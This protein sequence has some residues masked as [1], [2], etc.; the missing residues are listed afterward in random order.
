MKKIG[1]NLQQPLTK[2]QRATLQAVSDENGCGGA[3]EA[4]RIV[5]REY[6]EMRD[7]KNE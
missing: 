1:K 7:A 5:M 2:T 4:F 3:T 6:K